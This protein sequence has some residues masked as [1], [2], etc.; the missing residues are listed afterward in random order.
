[1]L[2]LVLKQ[3]SGNGVVGLGPVGELE[4]PVVRESLSGVRWVELLAALKQTQMFASTTPVARMELGCWLY[5]T[6]IGNR[7]G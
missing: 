3:C 4:M 6:T 1:M 2:P 5:R 7:D